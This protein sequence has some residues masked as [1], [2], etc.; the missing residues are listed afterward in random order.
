MEAM[1]GRF[2]WWRGQRGLL[3][4]CAGLLVLLAGVWLTRTKGVE[5]QLVLAEGESS[6]ALLMTDYSQIKTFWRGQENQ[7]TSAFIFPPGPSDW[8]DGTTLDLGELGD[9]HLEVLK[10]YRHARTEEEWV[11]DSSPDGIPAVQ[12]ALANPDGTSTAQQW[13]VAD[14]F[15][16][17]V[18]HG[19]VKLSFRRVP[20]AS[21]LEDFAS[22]PQGGSESDGT[23]SMHHKGRM[24]RI[25]VREN[26]GKKVAVGK[27]DIQVEIAAYIPDAKADG[28]ASFTTASDKPNNPLLELKVYLPGKEQPV[29]QITFAKHSLLSLDGIRGSDCPVKFWYHHPAAAMAAGTGTEFLQTPDGKL[30]YRVI[31]DGKV[32]AQGEANERDQIAALP[33]LRLSVL[34]YLPHARLKTT[35]RPVEA[36]PDDASAPESAVQV[37]VQAAGKTSE[38][39]LKRADPNHGFQQ[40]AT[41]KGDL[42]IVFGYERLPLGFAVKLVSFPHGRNPGRMDDA[43]L[44]SVVQVIDENRVIH[45]PEAVSMNQPLVYGGFAFHPSGHVE[46]AEGKPM[47]IVAATRDPGRFVKYLGG[48]IVCLGLFAMFYK[49]VFIS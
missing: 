5:G 24:Y 2:P 29:R 45:L 7:P 28:S 32:L 3:L 20:M 23:L 30:H 48:L 15:A 11:E 35:F 44:A 4:T 10:F 39:W 38:V 41:P 1:T 33:Q 42:G 6:D 22:P 40:I 12:L 13:L 21:M 27:T 37:A 18:F 19:P 46:P 36:S 9:V 8:P 43:S 17:E 47:L 49:K 16:A 14:P 26:I 25:P 34:K 31:T